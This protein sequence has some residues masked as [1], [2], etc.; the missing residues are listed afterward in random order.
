[1][2]TMWA[3]PVDVR[4]GRFEGARGLEEVLYTRKLGIR[5]DGRGRKAG[6][7]NRFLFRARI[8]LGRDVGAGPGK[9]G[10]HRLV[11]SLLQPRRH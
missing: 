1:M 7:V 3:A 5:G 4:W 8:I 9:Q 2:F 6:D 10:Q 11:H